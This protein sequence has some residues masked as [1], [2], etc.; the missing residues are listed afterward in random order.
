MEV[1]CGA[2]HIAFSYLGT[3]SSPDDE[4][5]F[6]MDWNVKSP[7]ELLKLTQQVLKGGTHVMN[8]STPRS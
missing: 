2:A 1:C 4:V 5:I 8:L 6:E 7:S 3:C